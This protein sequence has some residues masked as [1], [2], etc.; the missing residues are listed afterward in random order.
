MAKKAKGKD[1][2][3]LG[4]IASDHRGYELKEHLKS[5]FPLIDLGTDN[6]KTKVDY[7]DYASKL[8]NYV[9]KEKS[10]GILI[11][12]TGIGMSIAANRKK[13]IRAALCH[14]TDD[15]KL[16]REHNDANVLALKGSIKTKAAEKIVEKFFNTDFSEEERHKRRIKKLDK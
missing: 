8:S 14:D 6:D 1:R 11:C 4:F 13:G 2:G 7:P 3:I 12:G 5:K 15:A 9:L 10:R 16:A